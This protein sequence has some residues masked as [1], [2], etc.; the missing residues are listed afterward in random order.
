M[1]LTIGHP[2][3]KS[4]GDQ[5]FAKRSETGLA[6]LKTSSPRGSDVKINGTGYIVVTNQLCHTGWSKF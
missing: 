4:A 5:G 1:R 3:C 2:V 6:S